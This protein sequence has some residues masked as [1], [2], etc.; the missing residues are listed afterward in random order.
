[1]VHPLRDRAR[2]LRKDM[3]EAEKSL[4]YLLRQKN[5][6]GLKFRRQAPLGPYIV[7]FACLAKKVVIEADGGQHADNEYDQ[8]R[9]AWLREEG[10]TVLRFWNNDI[11]GNRDAVIS[12]I[13]EACGVSEFLPYPSPPSPGEGVT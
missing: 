13:L 8:K 10:F 3:T 12:A 5:L 4:W 7:D 6:H 2:A 9:D 1:M 11:L